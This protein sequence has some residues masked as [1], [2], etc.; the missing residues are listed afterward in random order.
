MTAPRAMTIHRSDTLRATLI[1]LGFLMDM[2]LM[3]MCGIP[4]YPR[5][6]ASAETSAMIVIGSPLS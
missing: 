4:K 1:S 2:Y 3:T 5:P 6:Q